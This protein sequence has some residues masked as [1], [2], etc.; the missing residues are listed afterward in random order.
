MTEQGAMVGTLFGTKLGMSR[1]FLDEG[2]SIP[3]TIVKVTPCVVVQKKTSEKD[4]YEAIQVGFGPQKESRLTKPLRGHLKNSGERYFRHLRE[5]QVESAD[6]FEL[7]QEIRSDIFSI[8]DQVAVTGRSKGR[9]FAGVIKRWGFGGG[10]ATHGSRSHRVPG[11]IGS[12]SDPSHVWKGKKLP[13]RMG[14]R[15]TTVRNLVIVDVR[16]DMDVIALRGAVPGSKN[17]VIQI[18][19][20]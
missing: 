19:R 3:V 12:S 9:G 14:D 4:G 18:R 2:K 5:I 13:G 17:S 1:F 11:S 16:P 10:R 20:I 6:A 8:G 15:K 7:G